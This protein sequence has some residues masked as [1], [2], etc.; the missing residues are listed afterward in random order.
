MFEAILVVTN[1]ITDTTI[2]TGILFTRLQECML[3]TLYN[4]YELVYEGKPV[5]GAFCIPVERPA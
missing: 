1:G 2:H 3:V 4:A 5:V